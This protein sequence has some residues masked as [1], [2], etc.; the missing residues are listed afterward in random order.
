MTACDLGAITKP[1]HIQKKVARLVADEFFYQVIQL[2]QT[3]S[4]GTTSAPRAFS[5][6]CPKISMSTTVISTILFF[7]HFSCISTV[8]PVTKGLAFSLWRHSCSNKVPVET[9]SSFSRG[10]T[11]V[12]RN[13]TAQL[14]LQL[15]TT[16]RKLYMVE[17]RLTVEKY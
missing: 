5:K 11:I 6:C 8:E 13:M 14:I 16:R 4:P 10:R 17:I 1:W 2:F 3:I 7:S 12:L 15:M 9:E